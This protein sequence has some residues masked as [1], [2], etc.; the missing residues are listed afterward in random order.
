MYHV[1]ENEGLVLS[2]EG[3]LHRIEWRTALGPPLPSQSKPRIGTY[4]NN[5]VIAFHLITKSLIIIQI[6]SLWPINTV[7]A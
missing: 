7:Q 1:E 3:R 6:N 5:R 4:A 2:P